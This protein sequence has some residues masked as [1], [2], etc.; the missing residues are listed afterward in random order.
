MVPSTDTATTTS[1]GTQST[2]DKF[3][4]GDRIYVQEVGDDQSNVL[5]QYEL[6]VTVIVKGSAPLIVTTASLPDEIIA[7]ETLTDIST[8]STV[9]LTFGTEVDVTSID[10]YLGGAIT[11]GNAAMTFG[12]GGTDMDGSPITVAFSGS[13]L[14]D[15][16]ASAPYARRTG[17]AVVATTDGGST[18]TQNLFIVMKGRPVTGLIERFSVRIADVST[19]SAEA[20]AVPFA[21][22]IVKIQSCLQ[23]AITVGDAVITCDIGTTA[24][25]GGAITIANAGSAAGTIDTVFPTALNVVTEAN[26]VTATTD[27]GSTDAAAAYVEFFVLR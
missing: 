9:T 1:T 4:E 17:T 21:G 5:D 22:T 19:A 6:T 10:T 20:F 3:Y 13:A 25:T 11:V 26:F 18:G 27:G 2:I 12:I 15:L 8:A 23:G 24:I 14:G 16:D 7:F